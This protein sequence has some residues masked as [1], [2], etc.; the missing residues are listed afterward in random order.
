MMMMMMLATGL[1]L[2]WC[3]WFLK[4]WVLIPVS[5]LVE[6]KGIAGIVHRGTFSTRPLGSVDDSCRFI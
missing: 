5:I 4:H 6:R 2:S 1:L 3:F